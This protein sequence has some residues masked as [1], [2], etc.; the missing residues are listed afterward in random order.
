MVSKRKVGR[1]QLFRAFMRG[2]T[3]R[4]DARGKGDAVAPELS[5]WTKSMPKRTQQ[6]AKK[7]EEV[8]H[9]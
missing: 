7:R 9:W 4:I 3:E 5:L 2:C 8:R 1:I 6:D